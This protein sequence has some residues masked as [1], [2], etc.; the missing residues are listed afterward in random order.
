MLKNTLIKIVFEKRTDLKS[1][2][3]ILLPKIIQD[4]SLQFTDEQLDKMT[5]E[6]ILLAKQ[7]FKDAK[8]LDQAWYHWIPMAAAKVFY[9]ALEFVEGVLKVVD[10]IR[11]VLYQI[12]PMLK[13]VYD[14]AY[15]PTD[16][17]SK[18]NL[19]LKFVS[20]ANTGK[21]DEGMKFILE[22]GYDIFNSIVTDNWKSIV[23]SILFEAGRHVT[24]ELAKSLVNVLTSTVSNWKL[25]TYASYLYWKDLYE[26]H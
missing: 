16:I 9:W 17:E 21:I 15:N 8:S 18:L 11:E 12:S 24:N 26:N 14:L 4:K 3:T 5:N 13:D 19:F 20:Y 25:K 10:Q 6:I 22:N 2:V 7:Q 1:Q 23:E